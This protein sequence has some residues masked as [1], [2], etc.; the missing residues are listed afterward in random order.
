M[1]LK[2]IYIMNFETLENFSLVKGWRFAVNALLRA[3]VLAL[4]IS[5]CTGLKEIG[6]DSYLYTGYKIKIDSTRNLADPAATGTELSSLISNKPNRKLL[7]MRPRLLMY[8]AIPEPKKER[9]IKYWLK[10]KYGEPPSLLAD[11]NLQNSIVTFE[12]RLQNRG[13]FNARAKYD[14]TY[15][16]KT[17]KV[18]FDV[19][20]GLPYTIHSV[21]YPEDGTGIMTEINKLYSGSLIQPGKIY[22]LQD[23]EKERKRID[24]LLKEKGYFY[25]NPDYLIFTVD[26]TPGCRTID[27]SLA[28]KPETQVNALAPYRYNN[29]YILD[30]YKLVNYRPDTTR[31]G[32]V[33]YLSEKKQF[34]PK[35]I[36]DAIFFE[37]DSI[38]SRTDHFNT[39]RRLMGI[40]VYKYAN[41]RFAPVDSLNSRIDVKVFLTPLKKI[42]LSAVLNAEVKS[43][44]YAGPGLNLI[45]KNRN[46]FRGA[47]L[48]T[49]TLGE[50]FEM[51]FNGDSKGQ[52]SFQTILDTK[53]TIPKV[54]PFK[55][56]RNSSKSYVPKTEISAG[57]GLFSRVDLYD[58]ASFN[59][60]LGYHWK[61]NK[62]ITHLLRLLEISYSNLSNTTAEF[63]DYL[64]QNPT[65]RKSFEEQFIMGCGYD[66]INSN[67]LSENSRNTLYLGES[68][69][70][71][72]NI[73][74][75]VASL[76]NGQHPDPQDPFLLLGLPF[77]QFTRIKSEVRYTY[78]INKKNQLAW[79]FIAAAGIPYGNSSTIP[80]IRQ[81]FVGGTNS[82][83]AF[84]ARSIGP[85]S[86]NSTDTGTD[87]YIDQAGDIKLETNL[88]YRF[89]I[90]KFLKG[91]L[92]TDAGNIWLV[93]EDP[94]RAGGKFQAET[95]YKE[96]AVGSGAGL[97]FDFNYLIF[98]IDLAFPL[99][100]PY[101]P[102]GSR[103]V[104]NQIDMGS[105]TWRKEN[106][107][108]NFAI[109]YPF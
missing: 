106:L 39:L 11:F 77:S 103:C 35:T 38:Y 85:G 99:Y 15:G 10:N 86:F 52:I 45:Y 6:E 89:N 22:M 109:G 58:L 51:Q 81:Y 79:R 31:F 14:L 48:L 64:D 46:T 104:I 66:F 26:T 101:L 94:Q 80:Y 96:I 107:V 18:K 42:S 83:R 76:V 78:N 7:W 60:S 59:T 32:N 20:P 55:F 61:P 49:V 90:Y 17:A 36:L 9:G 100:K 70:L 21:K 62:N 69:D 74:S 63:E 8:A 56:V 92:F 3:L 50:K 95:F 88:E 67:I 82:I 65:V 24:E 91:A 44:S 75:A 93:N 41:A 53:L 54:V 28:V 19:S 5:G 34:K 57:I 105:S 29:I 25:F 47:E 40:G 43:N 30:D 72:G 84:I 71:A 102:E 37:K 23:F 33:Y 13:N 2:H 73:T 1:L 68:I 98:R 12:N 4:L 97:R 108:W 16:K 87:V 27:V